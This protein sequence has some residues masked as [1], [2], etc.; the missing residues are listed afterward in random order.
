MCTN[1]KHNTTTADQLYIKS[2]HIYRN[3]TP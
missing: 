2:L 3:H 1:K